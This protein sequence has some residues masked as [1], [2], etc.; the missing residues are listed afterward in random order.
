[1]TYAPANGTTNSGSV[2][3]AGGVSPAPSR[4]ST[5]IANWI[6]D[7]RSSGVTT[8]TAQWRSSVSSAFGERAGIDGVVMSADLRT[9]R[10]RASAPHPRS[11]L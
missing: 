4:V 1:M 10:M 2:V 9:A 8:F 3:S 11:L 5:P 7:A 6:D